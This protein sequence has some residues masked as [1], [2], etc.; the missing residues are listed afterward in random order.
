MARNNRV[1]HISDS[2]YCSTPL[3]AQRVHIQT[4][5]STLTRMRMFK[6]V[7]YGGWMMVQEEGTNRV[8]NFF[9]VV[10][11][12]TTFRLAPVK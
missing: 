3:Y 4:H 2:I 8:R 11:G 10:T 1:I 9:P 5:W 6:G 12:D 7:L